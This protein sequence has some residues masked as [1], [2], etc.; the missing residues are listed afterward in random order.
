MIGHV[1]KTLRRKQRLLLGKVRADGFHVREGFCYG[2]TVVKAPD[3]IR[4]DDLVKRID[5]PPEQR[6]HESLEQLIS[7]GGRRGHD[8][9]MPSSRGRFYPAGG[10]RKPVVLRSRTKFQRGS[11]R[12]SPGRHQRQ[13][14]H[15]EPSDDHQ[16]RD[17]SRNYFGFLF[18]RVIAH[19][20][21]IRRC[22]GGVVERCR[23]EFPCKRG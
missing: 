9:I 14:E 12:R 6:A 5:V 13:R 1:V 20:G 22:V 23:Q 18:E 19:S 10:A 3:K 11:P 21:P 16:R 4:S 17:R 15:G 7:L 2:Q 8:L